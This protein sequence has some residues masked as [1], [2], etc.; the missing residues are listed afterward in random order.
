MIIAICD[1][2]DAETSSKT[3]T[4]IFGIGKIAE[5]LA[6]SFGKILEKVPTNKLS[7][8]MSFVV[9][10]LIC[11]LLFNGWM[12]YIKSDKAIITL[13]VTFIFGGLCLAPFI[14]LEFIKEY[15]KIKKDE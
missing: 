1:V 11:L 13:F 8:G 9:V 3:T 7:A 12:F 4:D 14:T 10:V 6:N 5:G 2:G 15:H